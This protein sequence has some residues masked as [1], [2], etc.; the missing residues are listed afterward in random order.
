MYRS[1]L[2]FVTEINLS[3][4]GTVEEVKAEFDTFQLWNRKKYSETFTVLDESFWIN[5]FCGC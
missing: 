2:N 1:E 5:Q 3:R 4:N